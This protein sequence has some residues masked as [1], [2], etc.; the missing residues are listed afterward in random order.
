MI[1]RI[2]KV[3][4]SR[5]SGSHPGVCLFRWCKLSGYQAS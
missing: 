1:F 2:K 3:L 4:E 5:F